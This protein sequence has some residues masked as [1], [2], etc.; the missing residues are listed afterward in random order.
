MAM[1]ILVSVT[2]GIEGYNS[3]LS[4]N[5]L[6]WLTPMNRR[7]SLSMT[8]YVD[9]IIVISNELYEKEATNPIVCSSRH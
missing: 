4:C 6:S 2:D 3:R 9:A 5:L 1:L 8:L 7:L